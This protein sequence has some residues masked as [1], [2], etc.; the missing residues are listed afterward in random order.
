MVVLSGRVNMS[1][2]VLVMMVAI[3]SWRLRAVVVVLVVGGKLCEGGT[4]LRKGFRYT[5]SRVVVW[6]DVGV[7]V[8][9]RFLST[10]NSENSRSFLL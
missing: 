9:I 1:V 3:W 2:C 6:E 8:R 10:L 5:V 4:L 7:G